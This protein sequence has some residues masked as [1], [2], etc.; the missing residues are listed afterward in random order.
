MIKNQGCGLINIG[1][2]GLNK[3]EQTAL[4]RD[5]LESLNVLT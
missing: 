1:G 2:I 4:L 3:V 5:F